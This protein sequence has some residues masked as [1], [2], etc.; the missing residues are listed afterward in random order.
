M[1]RRRGISLKVK[2]PGRFKTLLVIARRPLPP[3]QKSRSFAKPMG[4]AMPRQVRQNHREVDTM[5][6]GNAE[7]NAAMRPVSAGAGFKMHWRFLEYQAGRDALDIWSSAR[8]HAK[9]FIT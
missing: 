1:R 3:C 8:A 5:S 2:C 7:M 9:L 6:T 4:A